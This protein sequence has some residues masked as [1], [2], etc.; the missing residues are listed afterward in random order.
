MGSNLTG[1][2]SIFFG[3]S[4]GNVDEPREPYKTP[5]PQN[6]NLGFEDFGCFSFARTAVNRCRLLDANELKNAAAEH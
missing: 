4:V 1:R 6:H 5:F 2:K 3:R